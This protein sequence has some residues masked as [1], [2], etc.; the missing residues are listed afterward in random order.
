M[1]IFQS[2]QFQHW[3]AHMQTYILYILIMY[4]YNVCQI[5]VVSN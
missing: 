1:I 5:S 2:T 4:V 3:S